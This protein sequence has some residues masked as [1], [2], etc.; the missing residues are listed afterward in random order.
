MLK[1]V[2]GQADNKAIFMSRAALD[3]L[4]G[5]DDMTTEREVNPQP[6]Q[7]RTG[8]RAWFN[9]EHLLTANLVVAALFLIYTAIGFF[10]QIYELF[11]LNASDFMTVISA[12]YGAIFYFGLSCLVWLSM[13]PDGSEHDA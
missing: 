3:S 1:I 6:K 11:D 8:L 13:T 9:V 2:N 12:F 5:G 10:S 4:H 7:D